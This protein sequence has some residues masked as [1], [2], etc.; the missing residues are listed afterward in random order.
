MIDYAEIEDPK[1]IRRLNAALSIRL[2]NALTHSETRT[3]GTPQGSFEA[4]VHFRSSS[5]SDVFYWSGGWSDD[6]A[7]AHNFFGHGVPGAKAPLYIDVQFNVPVVDFNRKSGGVFLRH[8]PTD[9]VVLAHRGIV[10]LGHGRLSKAM[11]F[12]EMAA[13]LREANTSFGVAEFLVIG[14]TESRTLIDDL[15][16]F[17]SELRRAARAL[18]SIRKDARSPVQHGTAKKTTVTAG[19]RRAY[20]D[21][22]SGQRRAGSGKKSIADCYHGKV[23]R[24]IRDGFDTSA[25]A[26]KSVPIDLTVLTPTRAFL[27]EAKTSAD[28]Q[29]IYTAIGQLAVHAP[30]VAEIAPGLPLTK[31]IVLPELPSDDLC[32]VIR[33]DLAIT[34]L[35]FTRSAQG[36]ISIDGLED[37]QNV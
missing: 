32:A 9:S 33:N 10:T 25:A 6:K 3:I 35:T 22:F 7:V 30:K 19:K 17:S 34:L 36:E 24:A 11:L 15:D 23:I 27:F 20:F 31:V 5:G 14:E 4:K 2:R 28:T 8:I 16:G 13:T 21:E 18:K 12:A 26:L 1:E 29:S 37:F